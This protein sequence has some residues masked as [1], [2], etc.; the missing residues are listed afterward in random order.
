MSLRPCRQHQR[1]AMG[2]GRQ[3]GTGMDDLA[4]VSDNRIYV[5]K[6]P[7]QLG[8]T[9]KQVQEQPPSAAARRDPCDHSVKVP[10]TE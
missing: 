3:V 1:L 10:K 4:Q 7:Y 9:N 2:A 8:W 6:H 5:G